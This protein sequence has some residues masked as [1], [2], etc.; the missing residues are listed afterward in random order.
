MKVTLSS[1]IVYGLKKSLNIE[2][3][4]YKSHPDGLTGAHLVAESLM[5]ILL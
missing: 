3:G 1:F 5:P 2:V 4:I